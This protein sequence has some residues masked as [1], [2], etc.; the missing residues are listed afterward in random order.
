MVLKRDRVNRDSGLVYLPI[1]GSALTRGDTVPADKVHVQEQ[2][3]FPDVV[4]DPMEMIEP[5]NGNA[6]GDAIFDPMAVDDPD[7]VN[8]CDSML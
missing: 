4:K 2:D 7:A 3:I 5:I 6:V 1:D 8:I